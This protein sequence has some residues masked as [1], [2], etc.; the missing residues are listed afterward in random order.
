MKVQSKLVFDKHTGEL[1]GFL[2]LGDPDVNFVELEKP[3]SLVTHALVLFVLS[4][5]YAYNKHIS[6][7]VITDIT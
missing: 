2:D 1:I 6:T 4:I 3:D 5:G 7:N